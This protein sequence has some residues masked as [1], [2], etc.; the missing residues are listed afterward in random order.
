MV[1]EG[2]AHRRLPLD[3]VLEPLLCVRD[4]LVPLRLRQASGRHRGVELLRLVGDERGDQAVDRLALVLRDLSER[5]AALE[6]RA[7]SGLG[8][9]EVGRGRLEVV[10]APSV[11]AGGAAP[12]AEDRERSVWIRA[13]SSLP[14][15]S[16]SC[17]A[18]TAAS[19]RFASACFRAALSFVASTPS[20]FAASFSTTLLSALGS[21]DWAA[22]RRSAADDRECGDAPRD[23]H[24]S[25]PLLITCSLR[26]V[27]GSFRPTAAR[28]A[29]PRSSARAV[30]DD[31][32]LDGI[33]GLPG[34]DQRAQLIRV[35][36]G[37]AVD[38]GDDVAFAEPCG[39]SGGAGPD[40]GDA[41]AFAARRVP[42]RDAEVG[43]LD[44]SVGDQVRGD[45]RDGVGRHGEA[46]PVVAAGLAL[47]LRVDADHPPFEIE[48]RPA[49]VAV[50]DRGV[51]LDRV[52]DREAVRRS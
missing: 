18:L 15:A 6:A 25:R 24:S 17:P 30:A 50:V 26:L 8:D 32:Q 27:V 13:F 43:V 3:E 36:N 14:C 41:G 38:L 20:S 1:A 5:L 48:Q 31:R 52:V 44:L 19:T 45:P 10:E 33:A 47:D 51:G 35:G 11:V 4:E 28:P 46:D 29:R 12:Q 39:R 23:Q 21:P 2:A 40:L 9:A 22:N 16:V 49:R 7:E 42:G 34:V 37:L